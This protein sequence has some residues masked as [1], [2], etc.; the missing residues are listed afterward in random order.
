MAEQRDRG[1]TFRIPGQDI[2]DE[3]EDDSWEKVKEKE[4]TMPK[5]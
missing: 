3:Q 1:G 4:D 2:E 5:K